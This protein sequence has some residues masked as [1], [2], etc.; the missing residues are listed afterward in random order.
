MFADV[1]TGPYPKLHVPLR[2]IL[3]LSSSHLHLDIP[4]GQFPVRFPTLNEFLISLMRA[5]CPDH[6]ILQQHL[7]MQSSPAFRNFNPLL[8]FPQYPILNTH[9]LCSSLNTS[10][11]VSHPLL[12]AKLNFLCLFQSLRFQIADRMT[13][14]SELQA[15]L[16]FSLLLISSWT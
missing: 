16:A 14:D 11:K 1:V 5:T 9:N 2:S 12:Q 15:F 7:I 6:L 8:Y 13:K 10:D 3:K 4:S